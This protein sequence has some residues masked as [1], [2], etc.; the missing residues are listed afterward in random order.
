MRGEPDRD[1]S[2]PLRQQLT[3]NGQRPVHDQQDQKE[4]R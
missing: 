1:N 3:L 2:H 4:T